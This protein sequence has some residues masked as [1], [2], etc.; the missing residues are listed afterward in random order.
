MRCVF[1][2][3]S[4]LA[5][6]GS[7]DD[8]HA[9]FSSSVPLFQFRGKSMD[10]RKWFLL[11]PLFGRPAC[12]YCGGPANSSDH[13]P[14]R[15][16]LPI[17][18]PN[19]VQAMTIPACKTCNTG[20]SEDEMRVAAVVSTVSLMQQDRLAVGV[21]GRI[22]SAMQSDRKLNEFIAS[23]VDIDG[24]FHCDAEVM[25]SF[26]RIMA[27][28]ITGLLFHE[29]GRLIPT[30]NVNVIDIE[31]A[32][33]IHPPVLVELYRRDHGGWEEVTPTGREL[34]R[35]ALAVS[36]H[37]PRNMPEWRIYVPEYFEFMFVRR[38]NKMLLAAIKLHN[39]LTVIA[40]CPWPNTAGPRRKGKPPRAD[41]TSAYAI[42]AFAE[43]SASVLGGDAGEGLGSGLAQGLCRSCLCRP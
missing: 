3:L 24:I 15:C 23:R 4:G 13:T 39:A 41:C 8:Q 27:K 20:F 32:E 38:S 35:Q 29:F 33:N 30:G 40:E 21:G 17:P 11:M 26:R 36:G 19:D 22:H 31:H 43:P 14:P 18:L 37:V 42:T 5:F 16:L 28:T 9:I 10:R 6:T 12:C 2:W 1:S 7:P 34:E 25:Q